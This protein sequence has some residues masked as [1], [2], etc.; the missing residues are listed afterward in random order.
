[1][2]LIYPIIGLT[3]IILIQAYQN[4][5]LKKEVIKL[6]EMIDNED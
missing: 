5:S 2:A 1:M 3:I 4:H 6:K